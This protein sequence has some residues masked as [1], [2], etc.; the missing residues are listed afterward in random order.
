MSRK[1]EGEGWQDRE[2]WQGGGYS[3]IFW[4]V[5]AAGSSKTS[6]CVTTYRFTRRRVLAVLVSHFYSCSLCVSLTFSRSLHSFYIQS[7]QA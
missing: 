1:G 7:N 6:P 4:L 2:E 3:Q 5:A